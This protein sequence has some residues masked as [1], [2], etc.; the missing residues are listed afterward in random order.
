MYSLIKHHR[1]VSQLPWGQGTRTQHHR[2]TIHARPWHL[3]PPHCVSL[4]PSRLCSY[5]T[6]LLSGSLQLFQLF[7]ML[8]L[9]P[10]SAP[11]IV[12]EL[13][14]ILSLCLCVSRELH[15]H[16]GPSAFPRSCVLSVPCT[17]DAQSKPEGMNVAWC[18]R[19][20]SN[21]WG[22]RGTKT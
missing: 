4:S 20:S 2:G 11:L 5:H 19:W 7:Q 22:E 15:G 1:A 13:V 9:T 17:V 12:P 8:F 18:L 16:G 3:T 21:T 10:P 14:T 6:S